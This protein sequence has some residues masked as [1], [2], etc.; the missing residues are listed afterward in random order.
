MCSL[1]TI[2]LRI[3]RSIDKRVWWWETPLRQLSDTLN[4]P[5]RYTRSIRTLNHVTQ[6]AHVRSRGDRRNARLCHR[7]SVIQNIENRD[8]SVHTL[9]DMDSSEVGALVHNFR[10]GERVLNGVRALPKLNVTTN[11]QPVTRQVCVCV[12]VVS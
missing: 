6:R 7:H 12:C 2:F 3:A 1:A 8:A 10:M 4:I 9:L 5:F 11:I